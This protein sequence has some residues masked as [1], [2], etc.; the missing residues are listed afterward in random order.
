MNQV[1]CVGKT[2]TNPPT[3]PPPSTTVASNC[4][5]SDYRMVKGSS[6][7]EFTIFRYDM[8]SLKII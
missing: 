1:E 5:L 3:P 6:I 8:Q 2:T 4:P 7:Y